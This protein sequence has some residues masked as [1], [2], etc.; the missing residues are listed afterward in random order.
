MY[1]VGL[2]RVFAQILNMLSGFTV[3]IINL[4]VTKIWAG[5]FI[6][7]LGIYAIGQFFSIVVDLVRDNQRDER[8]EERYWRR[9]YESEQINFNSMDFNKF[10]RQRSLYKI[11]AYKDKMKGK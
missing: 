6:T 10:P 4:S 11:V 3:P 2:T 8:N 1:D 9:K 7:A 5:I